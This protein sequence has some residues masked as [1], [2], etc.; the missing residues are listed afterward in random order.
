MEN[1]EAVWSFK[2]TR[3]HA[4]VY[5]RICVFACQPTFRR[6]R[7]RAI[8]STEGSFQEFFLKIGSMRRRISFSVR[9]G[10]T[11]SGNSMR[12][13]CLIRS[14]CQGPM[15]LGRNTKDLLGSSGRI[16]LMAASSRSLPCRSLLPARQE[17]AGHRPQPQH[18]ALPKCYCGEGLGSADGVIT[19]DVSSPF[20]AQSKVNPFPRWNLDHRAV[21]VETLG[22]QTDPPTTPATARPPLPGSS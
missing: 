7:A 2:R 22:Y 4:F 21:G 14:I 16:P 1:D 11:P 10:G 18:I 5:L 12:S 8:E 3:K 13:A 20:F 17:F 19:Q 6:P 9:L 15:C